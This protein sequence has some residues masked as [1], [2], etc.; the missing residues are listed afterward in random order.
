MLVFLGSS[1]SWIRRQTFDRHVACAT[2]LGLTRV[3]A[4]RH[5]AL[6]EPSSDI[7]VGLWHGL[8]SAPRA[9]SSKT[10]F[11]KVEDSS[12][13][14]SKLSNE[15]NDVAATCRAVAAAG[16]SSLSAVGRR[17]AQTQRC[18]SCSRS[19]ASALSCP[20]L[21]RATNSFTRRNVGVRYCGTGRSG[22]HA[23][24]HKS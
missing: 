3:R 13:C 1:P 2:Y 6:R 19:R 4:L 23:P 5:A 20:C 15:A 11:H 16:S 9:S 21:T 22:L 12:P 17:T 8:V 7:A 24:L 18:L 10:E 14:A